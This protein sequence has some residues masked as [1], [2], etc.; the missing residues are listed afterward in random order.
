MRR[1]LE[2]RIY[3]S[4][5]DDMARS[6]LVDIFLRSIPISD[7]VSKSELV[8]LTDGYSGADI[9]ITFREAS[10]MPMRRLLGIFSP[11]QISE[12]KRT[13]NLTVPKVSDHC[14]Y[15]EGKSHL[16]FL[17]GNSDGFYLGTGKY[18]SVS[19]IEK[20]RKIRALG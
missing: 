10:M 15:V 7:D 12:L 1:R 2:K 14:L 8:D 18:T 20:Y 17:I 19:F 3:I 13:G 4:L 5:P 9:Q 16:P 6:E 11:S